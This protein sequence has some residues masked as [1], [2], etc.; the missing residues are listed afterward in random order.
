MRRQPAVH[1]THGGGTKIPGLLAQPGIVYGRLL[2]AHDTV[3]QAARLIHPLTAHLKRDQRAEN[4]AAQATEQ[5][6]LKE[7]SVP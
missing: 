3:N 2:M 6:A 7:E 1:G 4:H 5:D